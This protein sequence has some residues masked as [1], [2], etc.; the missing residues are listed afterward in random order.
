MC[1]PQLILASSSPRRAELLKSIGL[2]FKVIPSTVAE[3]H[4]PDLSVRQLC[5]INARR[6]AEEVAG[7]F[8]DA[9]VLGADT[10][11]AKGHEIF[12]K[13]NGLADAR[14]MLSA[15]SGHTHEVVTA[16][17][18]IAKNRGK[19][20]IFADVSRV[21]FRSLDANQIDEYIKRVEVLDKAGAYAVQEHGDLII[22]KVEGSRS[23]V[24]GLPVEKLKLSL[25]HFLL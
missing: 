16:V 2:E 5:K 3:L 8:P 10:L 7:W 12:G 6:K 15:L 17:C 18:L 11:V 20:E 19:E 14:Q 13:P 9:V 4:D 24:I 21:T 23:N 22:E 1:P 25:K